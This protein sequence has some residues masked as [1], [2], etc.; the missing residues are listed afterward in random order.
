MKAYL[1]LIKINLLLALR[2]RSVIFFNYLFPLIFFFVFAQAF[3]AEEGG[4]ITQVVTM[5]AVIGILGNGL[6]GAGMSA[7]QERENNILRRYKVT[8]ISPT[9]LLVASMVVGLLTYLPYIVLML[10]L[11]HLRYN[12][13]FPPNLISILLFASFGLVA[14]RSL[15]LTVAS[16]VNSVQESAILTQILY[17][18]MLFLSGSSFPVTMFPK[19]LLAIT[20]FIPATYLVSGLQSI[21]LQRQSIL[22]NAAAVGALTLTTC[23]AT[24]V[25]VKLFRWEKEEKIRTSA[26]L[27]LLAVLAPFIAMGAWQVHSQ[28]NIVKTKILDRELNRSRSILIRN[29]R[30]FTGDGRVIESGGV[31]L[32][33]GKIAEIYEG[34]S[35][36][37]KELKAQ[38]I[39]GA[40]KT[41]LPGL[42]DVHVHLGAP[43]G[44]Y[45]NQKP[46][47]E[48]EKMLERELAA[49][50]FSGITAVKSAGDFTDT[51]LK[52]RSI[53]NSGEKLGAELFVSGPLFTAPG[54]HGTEFVE[55]MPE[56]V[57][58][59]AT[60]QFL[61]MPKTPEEARAQVDALSGKG[62]D[63]I[64]AVLESGAGGMHFERLDL[65]L[66][67]AIA[68]ESEERNLPLVVHVG[69]SQDIADALKAGVAGIEHGS[70][71]DETPEPL[72]AAMKQAGVTYDPT[73]SVV[74]A[75]QDFAQGDLSLLNRPLVLQA[76]PPDLLAGTRKIIGS[77]ET[78][79]FR[80]KLGRYPMSLDLAK[81]NLV[82]AWKSGV[83]LV[84]GTDAGNNL[85]IH[86]PTIQHELDLWVQAGIPNEV[87][88]TAA[89]R[90]AAHLLRADHRLGSIRKGLDATLLMVEGNPLADIRA[91]SSISAVILKGERVGRSGLFEED[92]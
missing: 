70:Y 34:E 32:K 56:F 39:E 4:A 16:V 69:D 46:Y 73:L 8:P 50:L 20:Q 92:N 53:V 40:G 87:A 66:L 13:V 75:F 17:L 38:V 49:Y 28:T 45:S 23:A 74:E 82:R 7:V 36:D 47:Q 67:N 86:G 71:R 89:T 77:A 48:P 80:Q 12:M 19:W 14:F 88:L 63:G 84:T 85:V 18:S 55:R 43:G 1:A 90:N 2:Q 52:V 54:G 9:P 79:K 37:P 21:I 59:S 64:K 72:F 76:A 24:F 83:M 68:A 33:D 22:Q 27:W 35:P 30:I 60:E 11:A 91:V 57:R 65:N 6:F 51:V 10:L 81:V 25:S 62:V 78:A 41:V 31:L 15:G 61:R 42:I 3:K 58:K 26:K 44:F 29:A 5:V